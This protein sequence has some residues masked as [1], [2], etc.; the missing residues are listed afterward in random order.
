MV[1]CLA[2]RWLLCAVATL[3][4]IL[5]LAVVHPKDFI[6]QVLWFQMLRPHDMLAA[7]VVYVSCSED[8]TSSFRLWRCLD[9]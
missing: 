9:W 8:I 2:V 4:L 1:A 3:A 6:S 7:S 5:P